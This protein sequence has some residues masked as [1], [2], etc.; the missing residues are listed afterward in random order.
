MGLC[1]DAFQ[2][3]RKVTRM[4][5]MTS[6]ITV[7]EKSIKLSFSFQFSYAVYVVLSLN[8]KY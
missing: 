6:Q 1:L 7:K 4:E 5:K 3:L 2:R 8:N